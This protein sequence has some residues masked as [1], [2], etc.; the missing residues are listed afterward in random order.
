MMFNLNVLTDYELFW[1]TLLG[2]MFLVGV[3]HIVTYYATK[4][5]E[6]LDLKTRRVFLLR[7][8]RH[9]AAFWWVFIVSAL[10]SMFGLVGALVVCAIISFLGLREFITLTPV[11]GGD[12]RSLFFAFF[13]FLPLQ[14]VLVGAR[15]FG[16][17]T[18]LIPVYAFLL[19]PVLSVIREDVDKFLP[20][21]ASLQWGLMIAVYC[22]SHTVAILYIDAV[23]DFS[24]QSR[25]LLLLFFLV[26]VRCAMLWQHLADYF[27]RQ[28][29]RRIAAQIHSRMTWSGLFVS[30]AANALIASSFFWFTPFTYWQAAIAGGLVSFA[31]LFG[32]LVMRGITLSLG[33]KDWGELTGG[34]QGVM[35]RL[36]AVL[37]AAPVFFHYA[38]FVTKP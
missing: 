22:L 2:L 13:V 9:F 33:I 8:Q 3:G 5:A 17:F 21:T 1:F 12:Y 11:K 26:L 24:T 29:D 36:D 18:V 31:S 15:E 20:R 34:Q 27:F 35:D 23:N 25:A 30:V 28:T 10:V 38:V 6:R 37:Y 16:F 14:Y 32:R 19:L 7:T 4:H